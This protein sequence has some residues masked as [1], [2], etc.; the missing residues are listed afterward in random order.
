ML[1]REPWHFV[2]LILVVAV[3]FGWKRLPD[4]ARSVG[5]SMRIFKSEVNEMRTDGTQ[6]RPSPAAADTVAGDVLPPHPTT[7]TAGAPGATGTP[8]G[9]ER[10]A[11]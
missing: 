3:L 11:G 1:F 6:S 2:V 7:P 10:T 8:V 5:R 4:V 9:D